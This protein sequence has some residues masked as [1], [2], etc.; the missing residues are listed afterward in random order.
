[1]PWPAKIN[2]DGNSATHR[3]LRLLG[4]EDRRWQGVEVRARCY[5]NNVV[6]QDH[7]AIKQR[8]APMLGLK[9]FRSAAITLAGVELAHRV[10]KQ[11][12]SLP[13]GPNGRAGVKR[14]PSL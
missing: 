3:G 1:V 13:T 11:Q 6:E 8:C 14:Q 4:N 9:S 12:Y 7:R 2:V 5:L 10:R